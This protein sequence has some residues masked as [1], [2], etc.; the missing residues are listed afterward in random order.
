MRILG[1]GRY[2]VPDADIPVIEQLDDE[3][4]DALE[5]NDENEFRGALNDLI[6]QIRHVGTLLP[7]DDVQTSTLV[8]PHEGSTLAE[9]Q[10]LLAEEP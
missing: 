7:P 4:N 10:A 6:Q 2:D 1:Q 5:R 8:V 3:L 9:V